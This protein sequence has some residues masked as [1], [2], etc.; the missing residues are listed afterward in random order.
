MAPGD[1]GT[2]GEEQVLE[3][4]RRFQTG[5]DRDA[6]FHLLFERYRGPVERFFTRRGVPPEEAR[7]LTQET[8]LGI[9]R[10]LEG[11][12][13]E[14]RFGTWVFKIATTTYLKRQRHRAAG[15]RRGVE[16]TE[17]AP[18]AAAALA[19]PGGQ[20]AALLDDEQRRELH[21]AMAELPDQMRRCLALR[22]H[23]DLKYREIA[24]VM[25][26]SIDTVKAHLFQA[27]QR[28]GERLGGDLRG[29]VAG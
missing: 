29:G 20:L 2:G 13:P 12:R 6:A 14:A 23:Q 27:R 22:V 10:G 5:D 3:A 11:W 19:R 7:D 9:Y 25:R 4:V 16:V 24:S 28:L 18:G 8:F 21:R 15:K 17:E 26:L 1:H